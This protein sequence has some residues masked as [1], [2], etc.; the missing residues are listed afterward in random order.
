MKVEV[1]YSFID[2]TDHVTELTVGQIIDIDNAERVADLVDRGLV[3]K[4]EE[5]KPKPKTKATKK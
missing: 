3:K 4:L 5:D 1:K 2:K